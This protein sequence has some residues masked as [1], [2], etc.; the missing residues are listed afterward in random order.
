MNVFDLAA[1]I[2]L[3]DKEYNSKLDAAGSKMSGVGQTLGKIGSTIGSGIA[4]AAK[5]GAA[6]IG[7]ASTAVGA[8]AMKSISAYSEYEQMVGGVK[9]LYGNMGMSLEDYAKQ[10]GKTT[11]QVKTQWEALEKAQNDVLTNASNAYR[12]AGMSANKYMEVA[13][14][15]SAA[16]IN[17]L[18]GDTIKAA[19]AT[20]VAMTAIS[21]NW[22]TFGGDI[23]MIQGAFQG[24]A[25]QNY[26]MLDNLK[27]GYGGTKQ[28]MQ[29]LIADANEY[30][31]SIGEASNL[32]ISNFSDIVKAIDLIQRKQQIAG[33]TA[34]EASTTIQGSL[35]MVKAA[36]ENLVTGMA[37]GNADLDKM[38]NNLVDSIAGYT[39]KTGQHVNGLIDN[40]L[41]VAEKA[42]ESISTFIEKVFPKIANEIPILVNR[43]LPI[44]LSA[45]TQIVKSFAQSLLDNMDTLLNTAFD[46]ISTF[47]NGLLEASE[48]NSSSTGAQI[49]GKLVNAFANNFM[50]LIDVGVQLIMNVLDGVANGLPTL[51]DFVGQIV[52]KMADILIKNLPQL[53]KTAAQMIKAL[54]DGLAQYL[55]QLIPTI[56]DIVLEIAETIIDN[57]DMIIDAA[58]ELIL[59]LAD[60]LIKALPKL[61]EKAPVIVE[62]LVN[63]I[64][65]N[66]P[67]L[68]KAA[69]ELILK[70]VSGIVQN[71]PQILTAANRIVDTLIKGITSW[72]GTMANTARELINRFKESIMSFDFS[73]WGKDMIDSFISGIRSRI[74]SV[75]DA[76]R[77]IASTVKGIIGF[78][79]PEDPTSPLHNFHTFAP[80]MMDLFIKGIKDNEDKLRNQ[81]A[82]T[83]DFGDITAQSNPVYGTDTAAGYGGTTNITLNVY[84]AEGQNVN[85][86]ADLVSD[87]LMHQIGRT[88]AVYA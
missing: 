68:L 77:S 3:D 59:A 51:L 64:I 70:L 37:D 50:S 4:T 87:R 75:A 81:V 9:K 19:E 44:L 26:T 49:I 56:V 41:P 48:N 2:T 83:F 88:G 24:F 15:F 53:I 28:E 38:M 80:D 32:S 71:L 57:L 39:D 36:W 6:A 45:G 29:R 82:K 65:T 62:K 17:S 10:Q 74:S 14:S 54:A 12:T 55:P 47:M 73:R 69:L 16:L 34:R 20:D 63:A 86:L 46:M 13:T 7:A 43:T 42:L 33:T 35:G 79:E 67:K 58:I 1:R 23:G 18:N 84:G 11:D 27:L 8:L 66:A 61:L 30:A 22:N 72:F 85:E 21:D 5:V 25:K 40:I 60:G 78:S 76:A 31:K 52:M